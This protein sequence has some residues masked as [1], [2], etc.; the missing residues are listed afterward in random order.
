MG[1]SQLQKEENRQE[2]KT[3]TVDTAF[4]NYERQILGHIREYEKKNSTKTKTF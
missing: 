2:K 3:K 4:K 1:L